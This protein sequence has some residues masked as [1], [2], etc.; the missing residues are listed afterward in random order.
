MISGGDSIDPP[1]S[2]A[3]P[4]APLPARA[5]IAIVGAGIMGLSI[6]YQLAR[7][8]VR[9]VVVI[10][11]GYLANGASGRNGGGIRQQ[12]STELNIRLMQRSVALCHE[13]GLDYV[14]CSP[15]RVPIARLAAAHAALADRS[16]AVK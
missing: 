12:W 4:L 2:S 10:D 7:R 13:I 6:A 9:D 15:Y 14:S 8:G 3:G 5:E 11:R 16:K 1:P